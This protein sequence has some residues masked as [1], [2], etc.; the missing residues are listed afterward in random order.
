[1]SEEHQLQ[2]EWVEGGVARALKL[3]LSLPLSEMPQY[4]THIFS[5]A[6]RDLAADMGLSPG[7][8]ETLRSA[9][10]LHEDVLEVGPE[11]H[12]WARSVC[13]L[14][15]ELDRLSPH[16]GSA[17]PAATYRLFRR[18]WLDSDGKSICPG[19]LRE[20]VVTS[21]LDV[22]TLLV[23]PVEAPPAELPAFPPRASTPS[24]S[25]LDDAVAQALHR[26]PTG[27]EKWLHPWYVRELAAAGL[28]PDLVSALKLTWLGLQLG[29]SMPERARAFRQQARALTAS[30]RRA[31]S[32]CR[33]DV[34]SYL[35]R[36]W[37]SA[38]PV[39][40]DALH[41]DGSTLEVSR[42][43][44]ISLETLVVECHVLLAPDDDAIDVSVGRLGSSL[45]YRR[46][47]RWLG[48]ATDEII[49]MLERAVLPRRVT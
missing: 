16:R 24:I 20:S 43:D 15:R 21:L 11:R 8:V 2:K 23:S 26:T 28:H 37:R 4:E 36:P 12:D 32:P 19:V 49:L 31:G 34:L 25:G 44:A 22:A 30:H 45:R 48:S 5:K 46:P 47:S 39:V 1:M 14:Y 38:L 7:L 18:I 29:D 13:R 17:T 33:S 41:R 42:P 40:T 35:D 9:S 6:V 27:G 10:Q 3:T